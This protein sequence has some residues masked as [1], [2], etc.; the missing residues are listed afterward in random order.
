[1]LVII[2]DLHLTDGTTGSTIGASAFRDF[3]GRLEEL[4]YDASWRDNR[5]AQSADPSQPDKIY[6]PISSFDLILLG[7]I[8]DIIRSTAWTDDPE[9]IRP[10][11]DDSIDDWDSKMAAKVDQIV[12]AILCHNHKALTVLRELSAETAPL[13]V[14]PT[15]FQKDGE[16]IEIDYTQRRPIT[17][18]QANQH[19]QPDPSLPHVE[20]PV[21]LHYF[22]GNHDWFYTCEGAQYDRIRAKTVEALGLSSDLSKPFPW[23]LVAESHPHL[24][25]TLQ[26]H[27]L[28]VRHGDMYDEF[29]FDRKLGRRDMASL[30]DALVIELVNRFPIEVESVLWKERE[31]YTI[32]VDSLKEIANVR[33]MNSLP[34]WLNSLIEGYKASGMQREVRVKIQQVWNQLVDNLLNS[35]FVKQQDTWN[36]LQSV[37]KLQVFLQTSKFVS[38]ARAEG[39]IELGETVS[40]FVT[41]A[42]DAYAREAAREPWLV[43]GKAKY[44]VYGHTHVQRIVPLDRRVSAEK[45]EKLLYFNSGTWKRLHEQTIFSGE[46]TKFVD[47]MV[48]SYIAFFQEDERSGRPFETWTGTLATQRH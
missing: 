24:T 29:N 11:R 46:G 33:P 43:E 44:V 10:W 28:F 37:D 34:A 35:E 15:T 9:Q 16:T 21:R 25:K 6:R 30:G 2:S 20:V 14:A 40:R 13:N 5:E 23:D 39:L 7:D 47:F 41:S 32:F 42:V 18:P 1:M 38:I 31:H 26:A 12:D 17:I 4:V 27:D 45:D 22:V 19:H 48:M 8:F 36:P 3:R